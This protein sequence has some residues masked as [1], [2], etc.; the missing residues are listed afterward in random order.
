MQVIT[1][2]SRT[3]DFDRK[4][5]KDCIIYYIIPII[6]MWMLIRSEERGEH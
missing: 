3:D 4:I 6:M 2:F 1:Y 5:Q